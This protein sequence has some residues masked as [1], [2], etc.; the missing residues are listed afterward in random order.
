M[1]NRKRL[2]LILLILIALISVRFLPGCGEG[3]NILTN[4]SSDGGGAGGTDWSLFDYKRMVTIQENSGAALSSYQVKLDLTNANFSFANADSS[5]N[6]IRFSYNGTPL[7]YWIEDWDN[8]GETAGVWVKVPSIPSGGQSIIYI[9]YGKTGEAAASNFSSTFTKNFD[10]AN[11]VARWHM[12][13]GTGTSVDD[14][15]ADT[16]DGTITGAAWA[17]SDGSGWFDRS[18]VGFST[19]DSL[20][21][22]GSGDYVT[23]PD[24]S[25]L[26]AT[27][28]TIE[29]WIRTG[30][31]VSSVT[32]QYVVSKWEVNK[33]S[34]AISI[35]SDAV[36]FQ[37]SQLGTDVTADSIGRGTVAATT[38]YHIAATSDGTNK[39]I[40]INGMQAGGNGAWANPIYQGTSSLTFGSRDSTSA[41][42]FT[43]IIDEV[44]I[45]NRALTASEIEY[46]SRRSKY[47][48]PPPTYTIGAELV[49]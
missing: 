40:Y 32:P 8:I 22:D 7:S 12:D 49:N 3:L 15:S 1:L 6:D 48:N 25:T 13:E 34:Y 16:N 11:L 23:V 24:D 33:R 38:W 44:S 9:Y 41:E 45:Y 2:T 30:S 31:D 46:H 4:T 37:T 42:L 27:V 19:G 28:I 20:S 21:F 39:K 14:S 36:Y 35:A 26:D 10:T 5:G 17:G 43:G 47:V 29:A 18:D